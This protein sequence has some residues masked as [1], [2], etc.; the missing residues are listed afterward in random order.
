MPSAA[1]GSVMP[2]NSRITSTMYGATAVI[3]TACSI[4][5]EIERVVPAIATSGKDFC[6]ETL[7]NGYRSELLPL[8]ASREGLK[9]FNIETEHWPCVR[10]STQK[11]TLPPVS[12][13]AD[14]KGRIVSAIALASRSAV[15]SIQRATAIS[16]KERTRNEIHESQ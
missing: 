3:Q 6:R 9:L 5:N 13:G 11:Q 4:G 2:R 12:I 16:V 1:P 10:R 8:R 7:E 15:G 14:I